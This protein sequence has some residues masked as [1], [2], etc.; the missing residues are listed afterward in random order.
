MYKLFV[1]KETNN[2]DIILFFILPIFII[3]FAKIQFKF[4]IV[5]I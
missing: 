5:N 2:Y 4:N 3:T 1:S